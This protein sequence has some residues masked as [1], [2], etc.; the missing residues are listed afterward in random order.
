ME[1]FHNTIFLKESKLSSKQ[2][3]PTSRNRNTLETFSFLLLI[4]KQAF[5]ML[6]DRTIYLFRVTEARIYNSLAYSFLRL[7]HS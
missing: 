4:Q 7:N 3:F 5:G 6:P 2:N 1:I